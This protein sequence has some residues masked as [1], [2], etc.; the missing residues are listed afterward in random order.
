MIVVWVIICFIVILALLSGTG[1]NKSKKPDGA[2][3]KPTRIDHLHYVDRDDYECSIC[4][5]RF[6]KKGMICPKCGTRFQEIKEDEDEFIDEMVIW[7][8]DD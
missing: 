4:G 1:R 2:E 6:Q 8:D 7:E 3:E 5:T